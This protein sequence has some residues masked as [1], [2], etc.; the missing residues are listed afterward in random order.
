[1]ILVS[2]RAEAVPEHLGGLAHRDAMC[3]QLL[4][5]EFKFQIRWI[6]TR[7]VDHGRILPFAAIPSASHRDPVHPRTAIPSASH[8]DPA[9]PH[10]EFA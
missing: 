6:E 9:G 8:S 10:P 4:F 7:P 3:E 1:M 5:V 2:D